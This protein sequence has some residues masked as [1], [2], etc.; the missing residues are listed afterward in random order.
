MASLGITV[1][2]WLIC[3]PN[4]IKAPIAEGGELGLTQTFPSWHRCARRR[5][6]YWQPK[7]EQ[8]VLV[9]RE[10]PGRGG[11]RQEVARL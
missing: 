10:P 9:L 6:V 11:D 2:I 3:R 4:I 1:G 8:V 5:A 7:D